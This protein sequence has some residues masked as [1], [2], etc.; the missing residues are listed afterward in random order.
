M[1]TNKVAVVTGGTRGIGFATV[2][3][4]LENNAKV[5]LLG[6]KKE[7]VDKYIILVY[8]IIVPKEHTNTS[9]GGN[10]HEKI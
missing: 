1:L 2:E 6:S 9:T 3:K 4:F 5:I 8:N 10:E 7:S